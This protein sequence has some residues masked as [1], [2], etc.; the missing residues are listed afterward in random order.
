MET[1]AV[2][3]VLVLAA[4]RVLR[5]MEAG[6]FVKSAIPELEADAERFRV[7]FTGPWMFVSHHLPQD[8]ET[9][10]QLAIC[11]P[12]APDSGYAGKFAVETLPAITCAT[13]EYEGPLSGIHAGG[14]VPLLDAIFREGTRLTGEIRE[15][16]HVRDIPESP[17]NQVEIQ[18]G[19][20]PG[21][22]TETRI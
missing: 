1:K 3:G 13:F 18:I 8:T 4:V 16:H 11:R 15:I 9:P 10:F 21:Q 14:Y 7:T 5:L 17:V 22:E 19:L 2:P 12:I 6:A 20:A